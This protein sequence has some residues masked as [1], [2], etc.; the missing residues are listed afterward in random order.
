[1]R[2]VEVVLD[3]H[4]AAGARR[5]HDLAAARQT[6][7]PRGRV[8]ERLQIG[9]LGAGRGAA[10]QRIGRHALAVHLGDDELH[11][12][13]LGGETHA[14]ERGGLDDQ[15]VARA[16]ERGQ[17]DSDRLLRAGGDDQA[18]RIRRFEVGLAPQPR[19]RRQPVGGEAAI[20]RI[21][22]PLDEVGALRQSLP[23]VRFS[24][25]AA[26]AIGATRCATGRWRRRRLPALAA[27]RR[28]LR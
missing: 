9:G 24:A 16:A 8:L 28:A 18:P 3:Q 15:G 21:V 5:G 10:Q 14:V 25:L 19:L 17:S 20:W 11:A 27:S 22:E 4:E 26:G 23:A 12:A 6:H 2:P 13:V 1:M 7:Q